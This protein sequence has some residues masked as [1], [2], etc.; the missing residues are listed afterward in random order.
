MDDLFQQQVDHLGEGHF[1]VLCWAAQSE[2]R[3]TPYNMT[4][5]FDDLKHIGLTRTKQ[6]AVA[7]VEAL[8]AL[9]F[10]DLRGEGNRRNIYITMH[11]AKALEN[12]VLRTVHTPRISAFLEG[13]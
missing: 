10:V 2:G 12:L 4:N 13:H 8:S 3:S 1:L 5:C 7:F 6:T 9:R 11:G